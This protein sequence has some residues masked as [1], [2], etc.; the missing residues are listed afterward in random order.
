[1]R[2]HRDRAAPNWPSFDFLAREVGGRLRNRLDDIRRDFPRTLDLGCRGGEMAERLIG[3]KGIEAVVQCDLSPTMARLAA[4]NGQP[5]LAADEEF[6]PFRP[7]S[8]DL[9]ISCLALHWVNDLPGTLLQ[10]RQTL[11]SDGLLL[12]AMLGGESLHELHMALMEAEIEITGG[13]SPRVSPFAETRDVGG[14][15]QRAGFALPV[16]D[17]D[18][19]VVTYPDPFAAL[20]DLRGMGETNAIA[21]RPKGGLSRRLLARAAEIYDQRFR[22]ADG[23][24]PVT[25]QVLYLTGWAPHASQQQPLRPGSAQARLAEAL[26]TSEIPAGDPAK[27]PR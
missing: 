25:L 21:A 17:V 18:E 19:I 4:A 27:P 15:L 6:L 16:V 20:R 22:Q 10:L 12:A 24:L 1:M 2:Q 14:L 23:R 11:K 3:A 13:L 8:F 26:G 9:A 5:T 7:A